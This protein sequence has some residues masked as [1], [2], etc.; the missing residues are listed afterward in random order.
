M[1]FFDETGATSAQI[2]RLS[3]PHDG[4]DGIQGPLDQGV[5]P[6][7]SGSRDTV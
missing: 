5:V 4:S 1:F 2:W 6:L 7:R 3:Q